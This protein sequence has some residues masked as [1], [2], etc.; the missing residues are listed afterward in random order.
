MHPPPPLLLFSMAR[1]RVT[2]FLASSF[3]CWLLLS[4]FMTISLDVMGGRSRWLYALLTASVSRAYSNPAVSPSYG[5]YCLGY[6][7]RSLEDRVPPMVQDHSDFC[8]LNHYQIK[9]KHRSKVLPFTFG[10][11]GWWVGEN[12][13]IRACQCSGCISI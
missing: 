6:T 9:E 13:G 8:H 7:I 4:G 12:Y 3:E 10:R 2:I 11:N 5:R 1:G